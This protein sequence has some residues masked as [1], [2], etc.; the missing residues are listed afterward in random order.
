[1]PPGPVFRYDA[2]ISYAAQD[3]QPPRRPWADWLEEALRNYEVPRK[4][5]GR[6][7]PNGPIPARLAAIHKPLRKENDG[8][9]SPQD[10]IA[11]A[12][13]RTL[14]VV[15]SPGAARSAAVDAEVREFKK[16]P[17][18]RIVAV[19]IGGEPDAKDEAREAF[20]DA[21]KYEVKTDGTLDREWRLHPVVADA[22]GRQGELAGDRLAQA[23]RVVLAAVLG[24]PPDALGEVSAEPAV[25][26]RVGKSRG[27][28]GVLGLL[29]LIAAAGAGWVAYTFHQQ[30]MA[31]EDARRQAD[32]L[33]L[34]IQQDLRA[35]LA[36]AGQLELLGD[37]NE[38]IMAHLASAGRDQRDPAALT[39]LANAFGD[40]AE[41]LSK[42]GD[43][44]A[45]LESALS[46]VQVRQ[47]LAEMGGGDPQILLE[48]IRDQRRVAALYLRSGQLK[49]ALAV[50]E[51]TRTMAAALNQR[52]LGVLQVQKELAN[53][54]LDAGDILTQSGLLPEAERAL[55]EGRDLLRQLAGSDAVN[56]DLA[57]AS[58]KLGVIKEKQADVAGALEHYREWVT[59]LEAAMKAPGAGPE[60]YEPL[61]A[62][63]LRVGSVLVAQ[64]Q[65]AVA[66]TEFRSA[67]GLAEYSA[68][69][70]PGDREAQL[71][72]AT[73][74]RMLGAALGQA[75]P[76]NRTEALAWLQKGLDHLEKR[77]PGDADV[78]VATLRMELQR[79]KEALLR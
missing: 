17:G 2:Y 60:T 18:R 72:Y 1:M 14:V 61:A 31:A 27:F 40:Q 50:I 28:S 44:A 34:F 26:A 22:R 38:R 57:R 19:V 64:R 75:D 66:V 56:A 42:R 24:V 10:L 21:L 33:I 53:A 65:F 4:L 70:N 45:A 46:G 35:K 52:K 12:E 77:L 13:S 69:M 29:G 41:F 43:A 8:E 71:R 9:L 51:Q 76:A 68:G 48:L 67:A 16:R 63:R 54:H 5:A 78:R 3:N 6:P 36:T 20:P 39:A 11:L 62:A 59:H 7:T 73:A 47:R 58:E 25:A 55:M 37:V 23:R 15:C 32:E 30:K 74:C 49:E 79:V